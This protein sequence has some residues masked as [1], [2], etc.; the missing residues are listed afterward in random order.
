MPPLRE[1]GQS[2][3]LHLGRSAE[4]LAA[5]M[6]RRQEKI[7]MSAFYGQPDILRS[8]SEK[9]SRQEILTLP[10]A[11]LVATL[12]ASAAYLYSLQYVE[13]L[14]A[15]M[16]DGN[17]VEFRT[18]LYRLMDFY[19]MAEFLRLTGVLRENAFNGNKLF[20]GAG[21][22]ITD[23][24]PFTH[25]IT[26]PDI[27]RYVRVNFAAQEPDEVRRLIGRLQEEGLMQVE[28]RQGDI[29]CLDNDRFLIENG[30]RWAEKMGL[31]VTAVY[32]DA[33]SYMSEHQA[34]LAA[35]NFG[36][37]AAIRLDPALII[38]EREK[39]LSKTKRRKIIEEFGQQLV[40]ASLEGQGQMFLTIGSGRGK[41]NDG[42]D[43]HH[44]QSY[45]ERQEV[46]RI[47]RVALR[48]RGIVFHQELDQV[49]VCQPWLYPG[50]SDLVVLATHSSRESF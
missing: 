26:I 38:A 22:I 44:W 20:L 18:A 29:F 5:G 34:E 42:M 21:A 30:A 32:A 33:R 28:R 2:M 13:D 19:R 50:L 45:K 35:G 24:Y 31:T 46:L 7:I 11:G 49:P 9:L 25:K 16:P 39:Q 15:E 4:T 3:G 43:Y 12:N 23:I 41:E 27:E 10:E 6:A 8:A 47:L 48:S 36:L 40:A 37:V 17:E 1:F 14:S